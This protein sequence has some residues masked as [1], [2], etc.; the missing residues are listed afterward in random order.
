MGHLHFEHRLQ[1]MKKGK[2][3]RGAKI[4][5][6]IKARGCR[7]APGSATFAGPGCWHSPEKGTAAARYFQCE[8]GAEGNWQMRKRKNDD[9]V[10]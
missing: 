3:S 2:L 7:P 8:Q 10:G 5:A 4:L 6:T 9:S 1:E